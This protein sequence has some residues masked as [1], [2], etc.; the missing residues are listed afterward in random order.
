[1]E[2]AISSFL[3]IDEINLWRTENWYQRNSQPIPISSVK[4]KTSADVRTAVR[5]QTS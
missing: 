2:E 1:M 4:T 3:F 5:P